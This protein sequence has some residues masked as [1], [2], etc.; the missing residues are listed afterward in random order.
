MPFGICTKPSKDEL[1]KE[2]SVR[3]EIPSQSYIEVALN[4]D[5]LG[6]ECLENVAKHLGLPQIEHYGLS[7][8]T[9][10][11]HEWWLVLEKPIR[12]QL[13]RNAAS[14]LYNAELKFKVHFF[15]ADSSWIRLQ[16]NS[17]RRLYYL[18][19]K[20]QILEGSLSC[21]KDTAVLLASYSA[22]A[23]LGDYEAEKFSSYIED[24]S[25]FPWN[26][27]V[28]HSRD[29]LEQQV[30]NL[31]QQYRGMTREEAELEFVIIT[32]KM[33][34][35]GDEY[36]PAKD[37]DGF[38]ILV[39]ASF[40][41]IVV[42]HPHGIPP[43]YFRWP[44]IVRMS[45]SK[46]YFC[47]ESARSFDTI[48]FEMEDA[49]T[50]KYV[51]RIFV[52]HH[53]F[54]RLNLSRSSTLQLSNNSSGKFTLRNKAKVSANNG[55]K[56]SPCSSSLEKGLVNPVFDD[57]KSFTDEK[58]M[59][60][61]VS[62]D[63]SSGSKR[64]I[65][66]PRPQSLNFSQANSQR[67]LLLR[68]NL[69]TSQN[70]L[71]HK[72]GLYSEVLYNR[73]VSNEIGSSL[74][75][76]SGNPLG[77]Q[78]L[79]SLDDRSH[80][81]NNVTSDEACFTSTV[82]PSRPAS[83]HLEQQ[84]QQVAGDN[85][86]EVT[87]QTSGYST[88]NDSDLEEARELDFD[89]DD[90][91]LSREM[92]LKELEKILNDGQVFTEFQKLERRSEQ[93]T[94]SSAQCNGNAEK[95]RYKDVLPYEET[96]VRLNPRK[97][98]NGSDY[99]NA[100]FVKMK[101]GTRTYRY[102]ATQGPMENTATDFWQ[103]TW[104]QNV[105]IIVAATDNKIDN[106]NACYPYWPED[107]GSR[108]CFESF[109]VETVSVR[110]ATSFKV[111]TFSLRQSSQPKQSRLIFHLH[112]TDWPDHGV[113]EDP[114]NFLE[115]LDELESARQQVSIGQ[116]HINDMDPVMVHCTA[117]VGRTGVIILTDL[118]LAYIQSNQRIN[119]LKSLVDLRCQRMLLVANFGQY[120]FVYTTLI[121]FIKN[122]R[123]I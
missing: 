60:D 28:N 92:Q 99:I 59:A 32:Q 57:E 97:N 21:G 98:S 17:T 43:V 44:D 47:I 63:S 113:P 111:R 40:V 74:S 53:Q 5:A 105:R 115:F 64:K 117:G 72:K 118:M 73:P 34:G 110:D 2:I 33:D 55:E 14:G 80:A 49:A 62:R 79:E 94:T 114:K 67:D 106:K 83:L 18:Q 50:A 31:Y 86:S 65:S 78:S 116:G 104:E 24:Q 58:D 22:Q 123:L 96:R 48:H 121:H 120:R 10:R 15:V 27:A 35:F 38:I 52:A 6:L 41:G 112:F 91:P 3:V 71:D 61:S 101:V 85:S 82:R 37:K 88:S 102:I 84:Q 66:L 103:M 95:N 70:S 13:E 20:S 54:C 19:L 108:K 51:W 90:L 8:K 1:A 109:E 11:G 56:C 30:V 46:N 100:D 87:G 75:M 26:V 25:L 107:S 12:K 16:V 69:C 93:L 76:D 23:E 39:G 68:D 119:V 77:T 36:Y 9:K 4:K 29:I 81:T 122:S 89:D 7:Y 45:H 42:R